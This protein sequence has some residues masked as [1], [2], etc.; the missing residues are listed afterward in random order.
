VPVDEL[1]RRE[2]GLL[3]EELAR[4]GGEARQVRLELDGLSIRDQERLE[5]A[6]SRVG[7]RGFDARAVRSQDT[8]ILE[9]P[10]RLGSGGAMLL[11]TALARAT[12]Y[13]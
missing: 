8:P 4:A 12:V 7:E 6:L 9:S 1:T 5:D 11:R 10:S 2:R 13:A 3:T